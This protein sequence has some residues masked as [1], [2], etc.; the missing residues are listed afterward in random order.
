MK[1]KTFMYYTFEEK[2]AN[3]FL[4]FKIEYTKW[5]LFCLGFE[6]IISIDFSE[7]GDIA[8]AII[9]FLLCL[10]TEQSF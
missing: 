2:R 10:K 9:E 4:Y 1:K 5:V 7:A 6:K 8:E 3:F